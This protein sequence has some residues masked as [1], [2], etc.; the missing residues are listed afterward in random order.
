VKHRLP[1]TAERIRAFLND[2]NPEVPK[3]KPPV[4]VPLFN[5]YRCWAAKTG[6]SALSYPRFRNVWI[7]QFLYRSGDGQV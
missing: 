1:T 5:Q 6:N 2:V 4:L 7:D 3:P